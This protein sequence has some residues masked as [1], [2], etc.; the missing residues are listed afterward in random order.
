VMAIMST[1]D[2]PGAERYDALIAR[3]ATAVVTALG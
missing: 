1:R 3:A 2:S